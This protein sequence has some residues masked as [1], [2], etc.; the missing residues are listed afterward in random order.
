MTDPQ[1]PD[2]SLIS[3]E[4]DPIYY[5]GITPEELVTT[6]KESTQFEAIDNFFN[7]L[8][9]HIIDPIHLQYDDPQFQKDI[10]LTKEE[11][12]RKYLKNYPSA[13]EAFKILKDEDEQLLLLSYIYIEMRK[14]GYPRYNHG[15]QETECLVR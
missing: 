1:E 12:E 5:E 6:L 9:L 15:E 10:Q 4:N 2:N 13:E 11:A 7:N 8:H 14:K 3:L